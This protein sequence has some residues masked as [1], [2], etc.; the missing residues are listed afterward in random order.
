MQKKHGQPD[1]EYRAGR[2]DARWR[3]LPS[4]IYR[5]WSR[6]RDQS[7]ANA[8]GVNV[9]GM[10]VIRRSGMSCVAVWRIVYLGTYSRHGVLFLESSFTE[11]NIGICYNVGCDVLV[12]LKGYP[13]AFHICC[14]IFISKIWW[15]CS[16][17]SKAGGGTGGTCPPSDKFRRGRPLQI[18]KWS[19][20]NA[21]TFPIFRVFWV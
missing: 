10:C 9:N 14:I 13:N 15:Q 19:G 21:V 4:T 3:V 16:W 1:G 11:Y 12:L 8:D 20:P 17:A 7:D 2:R 5:R 18:R 6:D